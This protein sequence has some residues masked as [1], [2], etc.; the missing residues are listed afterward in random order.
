[1]KYFRVKNWDTYQHYKDRSPPWIK[2]HRDIL[3]SQTWVMIDDDKKALAIACML[4][5][6]GTD[7][8]IPYD[9]AYIQRVSYLKKTPDLRPLLEVDFIEIIG[10]TGE[11]LADASNG[12]ASR[13]ECS[14]EE[15]RD[16]GRGE[17]A[18]ATKR[19]PEWFQ[20]DLDY[21]RAQVPDIDA[22]AEAQKLKDWEFSKPRSD[23]AAVWRTWIRNCKD[24]G[25]YSRNAAVAG[26]K[27]T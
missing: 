15:R 4:L 27:W 18:S 12:L 8:K 26:S 17:R 3:S 20:P 6:A 11:V 14:S 22:E 25:K 21:A 23:W 16:R 24:S 7:N 5:A 19:A 2:L 10:E 9:P 1:M 13:T